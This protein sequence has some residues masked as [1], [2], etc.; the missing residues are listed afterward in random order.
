MTQKRI[1]GC[2]S[3]VYDI[4]GAA[5]LIV[6]AVQMRFADERGRSSL[7]ENPFSCIR[8]PPATVAVPLASGIGGTC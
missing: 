5:T 2:F 7:Q 1:C 6:V 4:C 3:K 8:N